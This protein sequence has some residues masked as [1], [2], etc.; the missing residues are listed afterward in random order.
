[1]FSVQ[2]EVRERVQKTTGPR[3]RGV[4]QGQGSRWNTWIGVFSPSFKQMSDH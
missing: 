3:E 2:H 4:G 1:M